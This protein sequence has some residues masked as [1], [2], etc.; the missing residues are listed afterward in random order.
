MSDWIIKLYV[1]A[2]FIYSKYY[3]KCCFYQTNPLFLL[4]FFH[5]DM[6]WVLMLLPYIFCHCC[7]SLST[8]LLSL[9]K[10]VRSSVILLLPLY[11]SN[12]AVINYVIMFISILIRPFL[13][14]RTIRK[15]FLSFYRPFKQSHTLYL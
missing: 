13:A 7:Y 14:R 11:T 1:F 6:P 5:R 12:V 15:L 3:N 4:V 2:R 10:I 8:Q 9:W